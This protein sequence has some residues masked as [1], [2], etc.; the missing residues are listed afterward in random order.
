MPVTQARPVMVGRTA[1]TPATVGL[2][3]PAADEPAADEGLVDEVGVERE[4][5]AG[6]QLGHAGR[7]A[8]AA[9]RPV[10]PAGVDRHGVPGVP[11]RRSPGA[12]NSTW[13][14]W[15][16]PSIS[17]CCG[18]AVLV[19]RVHD[20][21]P[22]GEDVLLAG[23][24]ERQPDVVEVD[25]RVEVAAERQASTARCRARAPRSSSSSATH[26]A[27]HVL[28][29]HRVGVPSLTATVATTSP[30]GVSSRIVVTG[31]TTVDHARLDQHRG[32]ADRAVPAHRQAAGDLDVDDA[33]VAVARVGGCRIA[34]L[35]AACPRGS[36]MSSFRRSSRCSMKCS[37]LSFIVAPGMTPNPPVNIREQSRSHV[38]VLRIAAGPRTK[39][40]S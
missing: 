17:G 33:P 12:M 1:G 11:R 15:S 6:P 8:G 23:A 34:P 40:G 13:W 35:I 26:V 39:P 31:S 5:A 38:S 30:A 19:D 32:D 22:G 2:G 27:R 9:R 28:D 3:R 21:E 10:E 37:R 14:Q 4:L 20:R 36:F 29:G 25:Q 24:V 7:R 16:T 18:G